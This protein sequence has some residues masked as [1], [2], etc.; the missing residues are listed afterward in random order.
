[1]ERLGPAGLR[2]GPPHY[3]NIREAASVPWHL[4][5]ALGFDP[6]WLRRCLQESTEWRQKFA[7]PAELSA[8]ADTDPG[9][10]GSDQVVVDNPERLLV[11]C[12]PGPASEQLIFAA[13][14]DGW[15]L[16]AAAPIARLPRSAQTLVAEISPSPPPALWM[17]AWQAWCGSQAVPPAEARSCALT[18]DGACLRVAAPARVMQHLHKGA[19][20]VFAGETW[21]LAGEDY[22]RQAAYVELTESP[23]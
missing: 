1:M 8:F 19:S 13:G 9:C 15:A 23:S 7:F 12:V 14:A 20:A 18:L 3:L 2:R 21:L 5:A 4:D 22:V 16:D 17:G 10:A 6:L 11:A